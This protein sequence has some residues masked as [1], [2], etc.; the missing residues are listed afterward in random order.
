M[1]SPFKFLDSYTKEDREI[2]FGRERE[3]DELYHRLFE[4][5]IMLVYGE[6]GT[7]KSSLINCGL[8]N[9]LRDTDHLPVYIRRSDNI[10][11]SLSGAILGLLK[12]SLS[13]QLLTAL[14]FKK[15]LRALS[16]ESGKQIIF[17]FDQFEELFIFGTKEEKQSLVQVVK[18]LVESD[19]DCRFIFIIREEYFANIAE[20]EK[21]IPNFLSNRIRIERMDRTNAVAAIKGPCSV[22]DIQVEDGFA[23]SL[24]K[25]LNPEIP[26]VELTYLQIFLDKIFNLAMF[27]EKAADSGQKP[28]LFTIGLVEKVGDVSDLLGDRAIT[29]PDFAKAKELLNK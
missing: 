20:F 16:I 7:G 13:Y 27:D 2:Y 10:L 1:K 17:I 24:L 28:L 11:E 14:L 3:I 4:S 9:K 12:E 23:E 15:A 18:A 25:K 8:I 22:Y 19:L 6:S 29:H 5:R 26:G 21:H